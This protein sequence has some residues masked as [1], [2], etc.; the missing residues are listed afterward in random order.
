LRQPTTPQEENCSWCSIGFPMID[1][2]PSRP[3]AVP[4]HPGAFP[5]PTASYKVELP[6]GAQGR[7]ASNLNFS[8]LSAIQLQLLGHLLVRMVSGFFAPFEPESTSSRTDFG[9]VQ[10]CAVRGTRSWGSCHPLPEHNTWEPQANMSS[11]TEAISDYWA[12]ITSK[13]EATKVGKRKRRRSQ[14]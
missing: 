7:P 6:R 1:Y 2:I 13:K 12:L 11:A 3:T 8:R 5:C 10:G 9:Q 4:V 14:V